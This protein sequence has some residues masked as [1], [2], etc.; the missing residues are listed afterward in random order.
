MINLCTNVLIQHIGAKSEHQ[1]V[2]ITYSYSVDGTNLCTFGTPI[3]QYNTVVLNQ[4]SN[5]LIQ[6]IGAKSVHKYVN[7]TH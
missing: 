4:C 1:Y 7:T 6:H 2:N 5:V 3:Y